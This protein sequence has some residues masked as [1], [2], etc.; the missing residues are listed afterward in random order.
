MPQI[1]A[2]SGSSLLPSQGVAEGV[3]VFLLSYATAYGETL[4]IAHF[5]YYTFK[6]GEGAGP[7]HRAPE[8]A[9]CPLRCL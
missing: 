7:V 4:T 2:L 1:L 8:D 9:L 6:V 5:P 3:T